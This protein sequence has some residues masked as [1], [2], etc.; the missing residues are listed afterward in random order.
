MSASEPTT[1]Q[2]RVLT[3]EEEREIAETHRERVSSIRPPHQSHCYEDA[4]NW[5]C[6]AVRLLASHRLLREE[7]DRLLAEKQQHWLR[8]AKREGDHTV[9]AGTAKPCCTIPPIGWWCSR[10]A[11]HEGP[12]AARAALKASE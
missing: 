2:P 11:G 6:D 8:M 3:E 9:G 7:R 10:D 12:C 5:P 4:Q 1:D